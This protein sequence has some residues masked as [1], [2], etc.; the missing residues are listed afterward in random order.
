MMQTQK[1]RQPRTQSVSYA[2]QLKSPFWQRRRL[3]ILSR[4]GFSCENC[5]DEKETLHVHHKR[6]VKGRKAWEYPGHEL[7]VLCAPCHEL[8]HAAI[9]A[10]EDLLCSPDLCIHSVLALVTGYMAGNV[11]CSVDEANTGMAAD[12]DMYEKGLIASI[13]PSSKKGLL[14]ALLSMKSEFPLTP[15]QQQ[16]ADR[17]G[18][19]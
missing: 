4:S 1:L 11:L 7:R 16:A 3:E 6:Y 15:A 9:S 10:L 5:G 2:D 17:W 18:Q 14:S 8:E 12:I 13:A 19:S